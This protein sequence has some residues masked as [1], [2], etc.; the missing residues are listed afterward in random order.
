M[1]HHIIKP[2]SS[3]VSLL[4]PL[5]NQESADK[6]LIKYSL[7]LFHFC[8][9]NLSYSCYDYSVRLKQSRFA[10][11]A[12]FDRPSL[13][14]NHRG[15]FPLVFRSSSPDEQPHT[16]W[17]PFSGCLFILSGYGVSQ[18]IRFGITFAGTAF[19]GIQGRLPSEQRFSRA[20]SIPRGF[21]SCRSFTNRE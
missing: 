10:L 5:Q 20:E 6:N 9:T 2:C 4:F 17:C 8:L 13:F 12:V 19:Q 21:L 16:F 7:Q 3:Q 11:F 18:Q 14:R 15:F 1:E